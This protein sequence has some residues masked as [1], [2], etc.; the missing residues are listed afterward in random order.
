MLNQKD[1]WGQWVKDLAEAQGRDHPSAP[2]DSPEPRALRGLVLGGRYEIEEHV[3]AGGVGFVCRANDRKLDRPVAVKLLKHEFVQHKSF[4]PRFAREARALASLVHPHVVSILDHG[5]ESGQPYLVMEYVNGPTLRTLL[6]AGPL[7]PG[8][9]FRLTQ[10]VLSA[11]AFAHAHQIVHRDIKPANLVVQ[12]VSKTSFHV[13]VLDFG[14][15]KFLAPKPRDEAELSDPGMT[16]GTPKYMS[17]EQLLNSSLA[18]PPADLYSLGAVL[19]EMLA[20]RSVFEGDIREQ[21]RQHLGVEPPRLSEHVSGLADPEATD[22]LLARALSKDSEL[23]FQ[24]ADAFLEALG[25]LPEAASSEADSVLLPSAFS[26]AAPTQE[27]TLDEVEELAPPEGMRS[28]GPRRPASAPPPPP[29][30]G[31]RRFSRAALAATAAV[32]LLAAGA[33]I[34]HQLQLTGAPTTPAVQGAP[35]ALSAPGVRPP[36]P[37]AEALFVD[38]GAQL[39]RGERLSSDAVEALLAH[40]RDHPSDPRPHL[41]LARLNLARGRPPQALFRYTQ[42]FRVDPSVRDD[43]HIRADLSAL[44]E[45]ARVGARAGRLL[46]RLDRAEPRPSADAPR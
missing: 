23:R 2:D 28:T 46:A 37:A 27:L 8:A 40:V 25:A 21:V 4:R 17:P 13:K 38:L 18:G 35:A 14:F 1:L 12:P 9:A 36:E 29:A 6:E 20:G 41:L 19:F 32:A 3:Q 34:A 31:A 10:Q 43:P 26:G 44:R 39:D 11:L 30:R 5:V 33:G 16:F 7:S 15:A 24:N 45:N 42:A 22:R